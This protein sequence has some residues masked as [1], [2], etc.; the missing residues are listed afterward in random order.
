MTAPPPRVYRTPK[1]QLLLQHAGALWDLTQ[2]L[3]RTG[4]PTDLIELCESGW[5]DRASFENH[6]P[7]ADDSKWTPA[8][9][10]ADADGPLE[11]DIPLPRSRIS[12]ILALGKNFAAHAAEFGDEVPAEPLFFNK[13]RETLVPHRSEVR[14]PSDAQGRLDHEV[15]LAAVIGLGGNEIAVEDALEHVAGYT[16]ANDLTLRDLQRRDRGEG[17]PWFR[18]KNFDGACPLGPCFVPRDFLDV[19]DLT[20]RCV[21]NDEERQRASTRDWVIDLPHAVAHL[22]R[23]MTLYPGDLVLTGT[24]AGVGPLV[25]GDRVLCEI[26]GIGRLETVIGTRA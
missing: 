13:L 17:R 18:S 22:S 16:V 5:F 25:P 11:L 6:L 19:G 24:P 10:E 23:H 2:Y 21:V 9:V 14:A 20:L 12:K 4:Q 3:E 8:D 26:G 7:A 1:G 15:E